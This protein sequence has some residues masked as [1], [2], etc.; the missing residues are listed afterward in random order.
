MTIHRKRQV[1]RSRRAKKKRQYNENGRFFGPETLKIM[2]FTDV[3]PSEP[4]VGHHDLDHAT[5]VAEEEV[6]EEDTD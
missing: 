6:A 4:E 1:F 5:E 3:F 2:F